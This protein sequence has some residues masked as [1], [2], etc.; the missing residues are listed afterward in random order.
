VFQF[1]VV[2]GYFGTGKK[3][4]VPISTKWLSNIVP[5]VNSKGNSVLKCTMLWP[6]DDNLAH[7]LMIKHVE[8]DINDQETWLSPEDNVS[9]FKFCRKENSVN[10]LCF[11]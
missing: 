11:N 9:I 2:E 8:P 1:A 10:L 3:Y 6:K 5:T 7:D 4:A